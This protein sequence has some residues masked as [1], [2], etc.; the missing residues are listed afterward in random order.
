[1]AAD[2]KKQS[3]DQKKEQK[4]AV[5]E[6]EDCGNTTYWA[7]ETKSDGSLARNDDGTVKWIQL[8]A[9]APREPATTRPA[10]GDMAEVTLECRTTST[11]EPIGSGRKTCDDEEVHTLPAGHVYVENEVDIT[12]HSDT[13][14][15]SCSVTWEDRV[16]IIPGT[17]IM[18]ARTMRVR[19]HSRSGSGTGERGHAHYTVKCRFVE[20]DD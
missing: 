8:L 9:R 1:M 20:Y 17:G 6:C 19:A 16:E 5:T 7:L 14:D 13:G 12:S 10:L 11:N 18:M 3:A 15:N 2:P 4:A